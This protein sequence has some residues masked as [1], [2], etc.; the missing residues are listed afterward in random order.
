MCRPNMKLHIYDK[1]QLFL[2]ELLDVSYYKYLVLTHK[3][4]ENLILQLKSIRT[5]FENIKVN[6]RTR[7]HIHIYFTEDK[8]ETYLDPEIDKNHIYSSKT[9]IETTINAKT[10]LNNLSIKYLKYQNIRQNIKYISS[11]K[12]L[13]KFLYWMYKNMTLFDMELF[14]IWS[15]MVSFMLGIREFTDIDFHYIDNHKGII[16]KLERFKTAKIVDMDLDTDVKKINYSM[17]IQLDSMKLI[18]ENRNSL[19][20]N[21]NMYCYFYGIKINNLLTHFYW[22]IIRGRPSQAAELIAFSKSLT[23]PIPQIQ[24]SN[25]KYYTIRYAMNDIKNKRAEHKKIINEYDN[26]SQDVSNEILQEKLNYYI[27]DFEYIYFASELKNRNIEYHPFIT[28]PVN[29]KSYINTVKMYLKQKYKIS[30]PKI[31]IQNRLDMDGIKSI[32]ELNKFMLKN[33]KLYI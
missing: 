33:K 28:E 32:V 5:K 14:F 2:N 15:G 23:I 12:K 7:N 17:R 11:I 8:L 3:E 4:Y 24:I 6:E 26:I 18:G 30:L 19:F 9:F 31:D 22:R 29:K 16:R 27:L 20:V 1:K 21:P 13:N 25:I 10:I